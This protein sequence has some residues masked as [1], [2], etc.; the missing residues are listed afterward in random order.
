M[1][2]FFFFDDHR[3]EK[4]HAGCTPSSIV[5]F[6]CHRLMEWNHEWDCVK[7][8]WRSERLSETKKL[9]IKYFFFFLVIFY[10]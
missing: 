6:V 2:D 4:D 10:E 3:R 8:T 9:T 5:T 1:S 7:A